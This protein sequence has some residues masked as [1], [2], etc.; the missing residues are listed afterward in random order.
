MEAQFYDA[1]EV[2]AYFSMEKVNSENIY[3]TS[4]NFMIAAYNTFNYSF[5]YF[6]AIFETGLEEHNATK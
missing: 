2:L 6:C 4:P 5:L 3:N 1:A